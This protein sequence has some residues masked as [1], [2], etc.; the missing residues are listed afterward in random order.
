MKEFIAIGELAQ[1]FNMDVQLL[2]YYDKRGL[3]VPAIRNK[4]NGRRLYH[5]D[6]IY[7]LASIR[8]LRKLGCGLDEIEDFVSINDVDKNLDSMMEH[9]NTLKKRC[10]E[11]TATVDVI[12][13][14]L[15]FIQEELTFQQKAEYFTRSYPKRYYLQLGEELNLFTSELFYFYPTVGFYKGTQKWFGAYLFGDDESAEILAKNLD[16]AAFIPSGNYWCGYHYGPY[17]NIQESIDNLRREGQKRGFKLDEIVITP[18][19]IDQFS[20][21]HPAKYIT[22]LEVKIL[23]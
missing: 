17:Q 3:L 12:Y 7:A 19:I 15:R 18:N 10:D 22:A 11:L 13:K 16:I 21:G 4:E 20:E 9:A 2:R 8:Y 23:E 14:K 6:Q 5:F 1:I